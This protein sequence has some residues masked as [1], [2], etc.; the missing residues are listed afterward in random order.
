MLYALTLQAKKLRSV[1]HRGNGKWDSEKCGFR[2]TA[3]ERKE[4][5]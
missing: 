4:R 1:V 2:G 5:V 3:L